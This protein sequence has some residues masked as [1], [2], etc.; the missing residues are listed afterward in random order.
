MGFA[1]GDFEERW[2][3]LRLGIT[4]LLCLRLL[5]GRVRNC[6]LARG[7]GQ[8]HAPINILE[9]RLEL[10]ALNACNKSNSS[11]E[12]ETKRDKIAN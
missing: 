12:N 10:I 5:V 11:S 4:C 8:Q 9:L 7:F 3:L 2:L 6:E 1:R